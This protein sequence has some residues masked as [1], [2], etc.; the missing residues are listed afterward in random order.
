[1]HKFDKLLEKKGRKI[2]DVEKRAKSDVLSSLQGPSEESDPMAEK[3]ASLKKAHRDEAGTDSSPKLPDDAQEMRG[4]VME[5]Q[6][7]HA[8]SEN[9]EPQTPEE[10]DE[11]IQHLLLLKKQMLQGSE[12]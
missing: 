3:L 4:D 8:D 7:A 12:E 9:L 1:M 6:E 10:I 11:K 5:G 2:S